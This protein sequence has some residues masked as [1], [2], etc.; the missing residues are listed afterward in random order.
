[1][2]NVR[3]VKEFE[4]ILNGKTYIR[5]AKAGN[6][7]IYNRD[8]RYMVTLYKNKTSCNKYV[9]RLVAL[10]FLANPNNYPM[11]DHINRDTSDNRVENLR[12]CTCSQNLHNSIAYTNHTGLQGVIRYGD[13]FAGRISKNGKVSHLGVF[14]TAEEAHAAYVKAKNDYAGEF[15]PYFTHNNNL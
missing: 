3:R 6:L 2:G 11:V 9:Y 1:M 15:S 5:R 7:K 10:A 12:W 4:S 14:A 8:G 13:K